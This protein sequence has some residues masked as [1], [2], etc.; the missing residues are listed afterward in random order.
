MTILVVVV[1]VVVLIYWTLLVSKYHVCRPAYTQSSLF[2][3][4]GT[5]GPLIVTKVLYK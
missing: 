4:L 1:V 5:F 2:V 3:E